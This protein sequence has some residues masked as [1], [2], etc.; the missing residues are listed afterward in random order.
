MKKLYKLLSPIVLVVLALSLLTG[1]SK[2]DDV[3]QQFLTAVQKGDF[4]KASSFVDKSSG[5][6]FGKFNEVKDGMDG[7]A[8]FNTI[9]KSY[10]FEKPVQVSKKDDQAKV[11][12][13]V[14]SVDVS[15]AITK[16]IGTVMPMAF[17][18]AFRE[19]KEAADKEMEKLMMTTIIKNLSDKDATMATREVTLDVKKN[20][21][22]DYKIV[23][24]E[25]LQEALLAN[26]KSLDKMFEK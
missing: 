26:A 11:K 18:N 1:C 5:N 3:V 21:D 6:E 7:K 22:G 17:A 16:S 20:K 25:N 14:T 4:Q 2:P 9:A 12:I 19:D 8:I 23:S 24:D 15:V 13:K 10:K